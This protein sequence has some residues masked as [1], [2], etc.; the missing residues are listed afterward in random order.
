MHYCR[1]AYLPTC[2]LPT[3]LLPADAL[4]AVQ[5]GAQ[6][7]GD[8][9]GAVGLLVVFDDRHPGAAH[10]QAAAVQGVQQFRLAGLAAPE[11]QVGAARLK[12]LKVRAGGDLLILARGGQPDLQVVGLGGAEPQV[13]RA[14]R[15]DAVGQFQP[16]ENFLRVVRQASRVRRKSFP[17]A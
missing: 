4:Q 17:E 2:L 5:V 12:G 13:A 1:S 6:G 7:G 15:D 10:G 14:K 3:C 9:D 11:A 16:L 8:D